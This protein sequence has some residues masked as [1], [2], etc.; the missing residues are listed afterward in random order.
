M[1]SLVASALLATVAQAVSLTF[2]NDIPVDANY[3]IGTD[4][5]LE[6]KASGAQPTDTFQLSL[7]ATNTTIKGYSP[8]GEA[9][10]DSRNIILDG[11]VKFVDGLYSWPIKPIDEKGEWK[12]PGFYYSFSTQWTDADGDIVGESPRSFHIV[13]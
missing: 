8:W 11:T 3:K 2:L 1:K 4:F 5:T 9:E 6:W 12:G 10:Y 13:D 7:F